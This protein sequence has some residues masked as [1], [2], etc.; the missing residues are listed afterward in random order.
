MAQR[1]HTLA[2][3][4]AALQDDLAA[5]H[6]N[7][8]RLMATAICGKEI[9]ERAQMLATQRPLTAAERCIAMQFG[10]HPPHAPAPTQ[11]TKPKPKPKTYKRGPNLKLACDLIDLTSMDYWLGSDLPYVQVAV[12]RDTT[13]K[14]LRQQLHEEL[15]YGAVV[16]LDRWTDD[17]D[18]KNTSTARWF[19]QARAAVN[20]LT[21]RQLRPIRPLLRTNVN[22]PLFHELTPRGEDTGDAVYA[23][24]GFVEVY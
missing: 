2:S 23:Y 19:R 7:H 22:S 1:D 16:G 3:L 14:E 8:E 18:N 6:T 12:D 4:Y 20:R 15:D 9:R 5:C 21:A 24:I 17:T 10:Y 13:L 11:A